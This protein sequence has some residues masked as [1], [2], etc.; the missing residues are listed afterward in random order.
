MDRPPQSP[1]L[2]APPADTRQI[3]ALVHGTYFV[4]PPSSTAPVPGSAGPP[5]LVGFHGYGEN[6]ERHLAE[7]RRIPGSAGWLLCAIQALHP[8]YNQK[9][10]DVV[11]SWMT[12]LDREHAIADNVRYAGGVVAE[13]R[14]DF[15]AGETLV[16]AGFSQGAAMA[17]RAAAAESS[18]LGACRGLI[19]LGGDVPPELAELDLA[20]FPQVLI[21]RGIA[22]S[23]YTPDKLDLDLALL[24][25]K[26]VRARPVVYQGGHEWTEEFRQAAGGFLAEVLSAEP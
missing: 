8:F 16:Y 17:Y 1:A 6:A 26:G 14:R 9:T 24:A 7:L 10:G 15:G 13:V 20:G 4:V 19:A 21:G 12:R 18:G 2:P 3:P 5:L 11:A 23:W 22:D 25:G